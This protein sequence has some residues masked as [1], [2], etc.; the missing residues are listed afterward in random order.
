MLEQA[1]VKHDDRRDRTVRRVMRVIQIVLIALV[2][3]AYVLGISLFG[4]FWD[5]DRPLFW[6]GL[7]TMLLFTAPVLPVLAFLEWRIRLLGVEY[8]YVLSDNVFSVWRIS[9][10]RRALYLAFDLKDLT[11]CKTYDSLSENEL[12]KM[13]K[14]LF[15]CCNASDPRLTLVEAKDVQVRKQVKDAAILLEPSEEFSRAFFSA[16]R[17]NER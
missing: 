2:V 4:A 7:L 12:S 5:V 6:S 17:R 8:D 10:N 11:F 9:G 14:A 1:V 16:L 15:A 3:L 13:K